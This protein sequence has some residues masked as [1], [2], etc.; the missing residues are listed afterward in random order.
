MRS[1]ADGASMRGDDAKHVK[2]YLGGERL[3]DA[4]I[5]EVAD[6]AGRTVVTKDEDFL[7]LQ[8]I[9]PMLAQILAHSSLAMIQNVYGHLSPSRGYDAMLRA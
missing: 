9:V 6:A 2:E 7:V 8:G 3:G 5:A 4:E 1:R